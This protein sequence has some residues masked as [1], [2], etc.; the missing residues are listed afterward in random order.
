MQILHQTVWMLHLND[1]LCTSLYVIIIYLQNGPKKHSRYIYYLLQSLDMLWGIKW[2]QY[3]RCSIST[4]MLQNM[5]ELQKEKRYWL[6]KFIEYVLLCWYLQCKNE[7]C[8]RI[9]SQGFIFIY[10]YY[11]RNMKLLMVIKFLRSRNIIN[12]CQP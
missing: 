11:A 3:M 4:F 7:I 1:L 5:Y 2:L 8:I 12:V 10:C 6:E 9:V